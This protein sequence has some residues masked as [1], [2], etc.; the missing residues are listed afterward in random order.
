MDEKGRSSDV[1]PKGSRLKEAHATNDPETE[2]LL[3]N[4]YTDERG[5][6]AVNVYERHVYR[7]TDK[8]RD[9]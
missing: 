6:P 1:N 9:D 2:N 5:E 3:R 8:G 4:E 7:H